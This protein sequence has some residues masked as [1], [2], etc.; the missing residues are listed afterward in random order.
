LVNMQQKAIEPHYIINIKSIPDLAYI[1]HD[2]K[3]GL[4]IG[5]LTLLDDIDTHAAIRNGF[6]AIAEAVH[7]IGSLQIRN[8][9]TIAGNICQDRKCIY[10]NQSHIDLFMRE[11][12]SPC[13]A[14]GGSIC[15][16]AGKDSIFHSLVGAK[17][18]WASCCSDMLVALVCF[19]ARIEI[20]GP[21]G[22]RSVPAEDFWP[23][24]VAGKTALSSNEL[25]SGIYVPGVPDSTRSV[26]LKYRNDSRDVPIISVAAKVDFNSDHTCGDVSV[27]LGGVAP[28]P[29]RAEEVEDALK[30]KS[31]EPKIIE[32][33][34]KMVLKNVRGKQGQNAKFKIAKT[35]A[36][37]KDALNLLSEQ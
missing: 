9:G 22:L 15:H 25:V 1:A 18:C 29:L 33:A 34:G 2:K 27:V 21:G 16:A 24:P 10:Y 14:K 26:Y 37:I 7:E 36:L 12:L 23:G 32:E 20:R 28:V 11:S 8:M 13:F 3:T 5:A 35:R 30:G 4:K 6:S 31:L 17:K 19:N